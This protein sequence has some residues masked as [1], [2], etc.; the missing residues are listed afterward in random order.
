M[1]IKVL[2]KE[3]LKDGCRKP[4]PFG[5]NGGRILNTGD[6]AYETWKG[7]RELETRV[8]GSIRVDGS[9]YH[10]WELLERRMGEILRYEPIKRD[11]KTS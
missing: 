1:T 5:S 3:K 10:R 4:T 11:L 2:A 8:L 9:E 6:E 7:V